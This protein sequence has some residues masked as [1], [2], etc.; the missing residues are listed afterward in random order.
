MSQRQPSHAQARAPHAM[1]ETRAAIR[2]EHPTSHKTK[3]A[4]GALY[5][6]SLYHKRSLLREAWRGHRAEIT[7]RPF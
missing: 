2:G 3:R 5:Q 6:L 7:Q 1:P 4:P